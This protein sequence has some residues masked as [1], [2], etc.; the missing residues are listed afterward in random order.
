MQHAARGT[1]HRAH[2]RASDLSLWTLVTCKKRTSKTLTLEALL[3]NESDP[4]LYA[5]SVPAKLGEVHAFVSHSWSDDGILKYDKLHEWAHELGG[6]ED[7]LVCGSTSSAPTSS[8]LM[9]AS[10]A[11]RSSSWVARSS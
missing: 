10:R 11:F 9:R 3:T 5:N 6:D 4:S 8:T 7:K 1:S 2:G